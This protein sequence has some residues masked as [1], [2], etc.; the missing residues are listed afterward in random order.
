MRI[1]KAVREEKWGK[2]K[3][4]QWILTHSYHAKLLAVKRVSQSSGAKTPGISASA[5][6]QTEGPIPLAKSAYQ[7]LS[8]IGDAIHY[9]LALSL[10]CYGHE[11]GLNG[12]PDALE[13]ACPV[14]GG[15]A[16]RRLDRA[17]SLTPPALLIKYVGIVF[18]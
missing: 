11:P 9:Y 15:E 6:R 12:E 16:G 17:L 18:Y 10:S 2:V 3:S 4:L 7:F 8:E 5:I 13:G 1:A 14:R